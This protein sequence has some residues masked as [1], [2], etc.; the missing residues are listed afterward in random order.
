MNERS[1][2]QTKRM[3]IVPEWTSGIRDGFV[4]RETITDA[5]KRFYALIVLRRSDRDDVVLSE[6]PNGFV[7]NSSPGSAARGVGGRRRR[8]K[9][10][11]K[12][13]LNPLRTSH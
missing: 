12:I 2:K 6:R 5:S 9:G 7:T 8:E 3:A 1:N 10:P 4:V 11:E 13:I